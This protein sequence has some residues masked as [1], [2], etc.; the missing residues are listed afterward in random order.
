MSTPYSDADPFATPAV[1]NPAAA[2]TLGFQAPRTAVV[3]ALYVYLA[4]CLVRATLI[5]LLGSGTNDAQTLASRPGLAYPYGVVVLL[6]GATYVFTAV[7]WGMWVTRAAR[8]LRTM[9]PEAVFEF[10]PAS[11]V[12]WYLV[13]V[14]ALWRPLEGMR[15]IDLVSRLSIDIED[16]PKPAPVGPWWAL[17]LVEGILA[18]I[19]AASQAWV[20][21]AI[22]AGMA[23][24]LAWTATRMIIAIN[25]TQRRWQAG[26][27][28]DLRNL[29]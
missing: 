20:I 29:S 2:S 12:W 1:G 19:G 14:L 11:H 10:S 22:A 28:R 4:L 8:N 17:F 24:G 23:C 9:A 18:W 7:L 5:V 13:P 3:K 21:Q 16:A 6:A 27:A 15:E 26:L 25:E